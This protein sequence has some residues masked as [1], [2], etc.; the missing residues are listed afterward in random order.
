MTNNQLF[1]SLVGAL[2][3]ILFGFFGFT[4]K[5]I[6]TKFDGLNRELKLEFERIELLLKL[7]EAI[8]HPEKP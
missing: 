6:D 7:H 4:F 2:L 3:V 8:H 5:Y 1:F